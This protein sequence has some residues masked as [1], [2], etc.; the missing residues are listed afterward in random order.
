[1]NITP[2]KSIAYLTDFLLDA[3]AMEKICRMVVGCDTIVCES[4]YL[5]EDLSLAIKNFHMTA[6]QAA[7]IA[8]RSQCKQLVLFH[9]SERYQ[10]N[11]LCFLDE[12]RAIF[13][14]T[15]FAEEWE[16]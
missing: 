9:L 1:M 16:C 6:T 14:N 10:G 13:P 12:A 11:W 8:V 3:T 2:G 4:Q 15:T 5:H 7:Q